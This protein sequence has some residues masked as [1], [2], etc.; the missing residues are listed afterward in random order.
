MNNPDFEPLEG[1][2]LAAFCFASLLIIAA[3]AAIVACWR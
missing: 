2:H 3:F 1:M